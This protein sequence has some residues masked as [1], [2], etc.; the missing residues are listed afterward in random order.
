MAVYKIWVKVP[1]GANSSQK[2][3][4]LIEIQ[5]NNPADAI[6]IARGQYGDGN[7]TPS[8]TKVRD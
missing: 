3:P 7:V 1:V 4:I 6:A 5:A 8:A 2:R